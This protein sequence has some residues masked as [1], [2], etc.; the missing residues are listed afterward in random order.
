MKSCSV[1]KII[2][3]I[4]IGAFLILE[5]SSSVAAFSPVFP[6]NNQASATKTTL[7]A[8]P[9]T[10]EVC[11]FKDCRRVGGGARL[12][13][14]VN[15]VLEEKDMVGA[16]TVEK[17]GCQGECGYGPNLLID[18]KKLINRVKSREA[19]LKALGIEEE[20]QQEE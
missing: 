6:T 12:E 18:G 16:V 9:E 20:E 3:S 13:K 4:L 14:L 7:A 17:C 1:Q 11:G 15:S 5:G 10:V 8:T 2:P 19:V